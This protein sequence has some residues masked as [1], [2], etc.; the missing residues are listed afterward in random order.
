[1]RPAK[2]LSFAKF[3]QSKEETVVSRATGP[4]EEE[5]VT[6]TAPKPPINHLSYL[7]SMQVAQQSGMP[8]PNDDLVG[9]PW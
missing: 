4:V 8:E 9:H 1:M 5:K 7:G 6:I 2:R 3:L